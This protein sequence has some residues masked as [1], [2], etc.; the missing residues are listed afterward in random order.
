MT[1]INRRNFLKLGSGI[2]VSSAVAGCS[3]MQIGGATKKVV[4]IGGGTGGATA[5]KYLRMFDPSIEVTLIEANKHYHTCYMSNEVLSGERTM[6]SIRF[7]Y[8]GLQAHGVNVVHDLVTGIDANA[9]VIKTKSGQTFSYD[10]A[11]V[12][13][14]IDFKWEAIE[15]Y[16]AKVAETIPHAWK[17]GPQTATLR[18]Q[19]TDMRNGGTVVIA[20][21]GNPFRCPPGPYERASQ[22]AHYLKQHKPKSKILILD[23]KDKFSKKGL[24]TQGW[25][26]LYGYGTKNSMIEW[27]SA[28]Q[29]GKVESVDAKN[30]TVQAEVEKFKADVI[31]V[32]PPQKAG[33]I[34]F[35]SGLTKGA[36]CPI[37]KLSFESTLHPNIHVIGDT[38]AASKMPKSG[39]SANVQAKA[40]ASAIVDLFAEREPGMPSYQNTCYS[41]IGK[42]YGISVAVVYKY[43]KAENMIVKVKG[44]GGLTPKNASKQALK[45][46]SQYAHGWFN[47]IT[48]DIF[49]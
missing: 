32:I 28:A 6:D 39:Y 31:N 9:R 49:G 11:I 36:W 23:A 38:S 10:R 26:R 5:A 15:G 27:V 47:N 30:R 46:E 40:C 17:A 43:N 1:T 19:L 8:D 34:A 45:R 16:N 3:G 2:L 24:F 48:N 14:G 33:K 20:P 7:G 41:V 42:D 44:S 35:S 4:V 22:I 29:G 25:K 12:S 21:P 37:N 13:P 18:K